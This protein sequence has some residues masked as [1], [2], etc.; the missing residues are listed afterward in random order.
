MDVSRGG[1]HF[2]TASCRSVVNVAM[3]HR[4]GREFPRKATRFKVP[5]ELGLWRNSAGL[6]VARPGGSA[7][8]P[9]EDHIPADG[10]RESEWNFIGRIVLLL[11]A[12]ARRIS[13]VTVGPGR[14]GDPLP[15]HGFP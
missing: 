2:P 1:R 12:G 3:P 9:R 8:A 14:N 7:P 13:P 10:V 4:R 11:Q 5:S 6:K 15:L